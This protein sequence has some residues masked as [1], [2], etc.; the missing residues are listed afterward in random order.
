MAPKATRRSPRPT[1]SPARGRSPAPAAKKSPAAASKSPARPSRKKAAAAAGT[2]VSLSTDGDTELKAWQASK[3][4]ASNGHAASEA[5]E[6]EFGGP[7]GAVGIMIALPLTIFMLFFGCS[8]KDACVTSLAGAVELPERLMRGL[9]EEKLWSWEATLAVFAWTA[10]HFLLYLVLPG[11]VAPGVTLRDGSRLS[12]HINGHLAFW[13]CA[14]ALAVAQG[15]G[16]VQLSWLYDHYLELM[17][18]S[19]ALSVCVSVYCYAASFRRGELLAEGGQSGNVLYDFFIGRP[20]NPRVG[21]LDLKEACELRP[22][23]VGWALLN[24]GMA[25]KQHELTGAVSGPMVLVNLFQGLYV[26]DAL[27]QEQAILTTMDITTDGFG[28]M[29]AFG[30]L[31][32]VPFTYSLQARLLVEHDPGLPPWALGLIAGLNFLGYAVFRGSNS[33]K[34]AFRRDPAAPAVRHLQ[35]MPTKRGTRLLTSGWWGMARK[36]NYTGDWLMGLAW[37]LCC[38]AT[39]PLAYFY[40]IYFFVL[41]VH[42]AM[43]DDHMCSVKYGDDWKAY[44][45]KVPAL[46]V[47]KLI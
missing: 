23:L 45:A 6:F 44:K 8:S 16:G 9:A 29:L 24:A 7:I 32:W 15:A 22:G 11:T 17:S 26:W 40:A 43:R 35:F 2:A 33:E 37:C 38:G 41:L 47:P 27:Y 3:L 21:K 34:D 31:S 12:Y 25:C 42:R 5:S 19:M 28:Y 4:T 18:G 10:L 20:L 36:I 39:T 30:D 13:L 1:A 14:V 46:F